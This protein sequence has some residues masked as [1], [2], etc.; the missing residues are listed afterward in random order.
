MK[1]VLET[2]HIHSAHAIIGVSMGSTTTIA[3]ASQHPDRLTDFVAGDFH[4]ASGKAD[5]TTRDQHDQVANNHGM[6]ALGK[7]FAERWLTGKS[8]DSPEWN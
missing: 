2:L 3:V 4:I 6:E 8:R 1:A 5:M 7:H